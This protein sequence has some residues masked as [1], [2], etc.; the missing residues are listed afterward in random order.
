MDKQ[1]G[2]K[3]IGISIQQVLLAFLCGLIGF[4]GVAIVDAVVRGYQK[5]RETINNI[6]KRGVKVKI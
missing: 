5:R 6:K 4:F 2:Y 3:M 1:W